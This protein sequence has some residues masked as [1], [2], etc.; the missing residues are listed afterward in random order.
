V[1]KFGALHVALAS[2]GIMGVDEWLTSNHSI[3]MKKFR[4]VIDINLMGCV[5]MTK[6]ASA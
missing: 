3:D 6:Y 2:A 5:Y 1:A 4:K